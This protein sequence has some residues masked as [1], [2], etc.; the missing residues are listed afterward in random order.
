MLEL[1]DIRRRGTDKRVSLRLYPG[2]IVGVTGL[3]GA[4]KTELIRSIIG[5]DKMDEGQIFV[6]GRPVTIRSPPGM[7]MLCALR[8]CPRTASW[9][10]WPSSAASGKI[11][12]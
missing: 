1:K 10:G 4:G 7:P 11:S 9:K 8:P 6:K 3:I 5:L 2:E 12:P